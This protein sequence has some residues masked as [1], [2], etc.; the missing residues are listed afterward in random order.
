MK[1][2]G[3][4]NVLMLRHAF[5]GRPSGAAM[6]FSS[7]AGKS[8]ALLSTMSAQ[9]KL[10]DI[11]S[12]CY[13][14]VELPRRDCLVALSRAMRCPWLVMRPMIGDGMQSGLCGDQYEVCEVMFE[15]Q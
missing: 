5:S 6:A 9:G 12:H 7:S 11:L 2:S 14:Q 4:K 10:Q 1:E 8:L 13:W 3:P 15:T